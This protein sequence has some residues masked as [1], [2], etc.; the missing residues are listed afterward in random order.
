MLFPLV[1]GHLARLVL[2]FTFKASSADTV[3]ALNGHGKVV[4]FE[5]PVENLAPAKKF[6]SKLLVTEKVGCLRTGPVTR[7]AQ[8]LGHRLSEIENGRMIMLVAE[9]SG[10][11][12]SVG[13]VEQLTGGRSNTGY[14]G[15]GVARNKEGFRPRQEGDDNASGIG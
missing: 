13:E 15:V 4:H 1:H 12:V 11:V 7:E 10:Q 8:C 5:I 6:Y 3:V 2:N 14:L 9:V